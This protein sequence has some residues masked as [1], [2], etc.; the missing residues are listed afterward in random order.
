VVA[1]P[2]GRRFV[3]ALQDE[4]ETT[5]SPPPGL[6]LAGYRAALLARFANPGIRHRNV[7]IAMDGSQKLPQRLL[8]PIAARLARGQGIETL[9][10]AVAGWIRWQSGR[11]DAGTAFAVDDPL[12]GETARRLA[13][14]HDP[15][16][17]V[18]ALLAIQSIFLP[19]LASDPRFVEAVTRQLRRLAERGAE[20]ILM[21]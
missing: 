12:A 14:L 15:A 8:A 11:T 3:E 20:A 17:Q 18:G 6:D 7:Q 10:L 4:A 9:A 2:G 5:L 21:V 13:G 1:T 16:D 19:A